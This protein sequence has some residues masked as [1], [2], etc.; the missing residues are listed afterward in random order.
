MLSRHFPARNTIPLRMP[1]TLEADL[2][3]RPRNGQ[4]IARIVIYDRYAQ[5]SQHGAGFARR[6]VSMSA[7]RSC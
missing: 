4:S 1:L 7:T 6:L 3:Q 5:A 2:L